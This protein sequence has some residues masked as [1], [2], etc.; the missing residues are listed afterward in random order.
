M[1]ANAFVYS[2][3]KFEDFLLNKDI[4]KSVDPDQLFSEEA[5]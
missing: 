5:N 4:A 2:N 3:N 1:V